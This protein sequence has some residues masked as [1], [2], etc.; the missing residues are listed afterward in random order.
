SLIVY[1]KFVGPAEPAFYD[2][3]VSGIDFAVGGIQAFSGVD[4]TNP[5]D[6]ENDANTNG[7]NHDTP[8][9]TT[10][11]NNTMLVTSHTYAS[12]R[13]WTPGT[14]GLTEAFDQ[15]SGANSAT[16][17]SISGN[18]QFD[19]TAGGTGAKR[20][21]AAGDADRG[22]THI[23]ALRPASM[24]ITIATPAG[25]LAGDVM[26]ASIGFTNPAATVPVP[27]G[28]SLLDRVDNPNGSANSL[29]VYLRVA[30]AGEPASHTWTVSGATFLVGG[31][32][33]FSGVDTVSPV[34]VKGGQ[35]TP[36]GGCGG[37]PTAHPTPD[38][39]TTVANTMLVTSH[40]FAS[41][42]TWTAPAG[43]TESFDQPNGPNNANGQSI[44]G[45]RVLQAG[46]GATGAKSATAAGNGDEGNAHIVALRPFVAVA[47]PGSFNAFET[48]TGAGAITGQV[49]TKLVATNF[50]LD[51]VAILSG[52]QLAAFNDTVQVDLVTGSTGGANC[53]GTPVAI[54]GTSQNVNLT[55]GRGA[56]GAFNAASAYPDVRVRMR[57][58]VASPTVTTCSTD[59]FTIRPVAFS[60]PASTDMTNTGSSGAPNKKAGAAFTLSVG[61]GAGYTG[62]P[63]IDSSKITAHAGAI[64]VGAL[65][66]GFG[67]AVGGT[68]SG[69]AFTYSEVG[70]FTIGINGVY[71]DAF[72]NSS[73]DRGNGDCTL[74]FSNLLVGGRYGCY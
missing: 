43:M 10:T 34:D 68:A 12:S 48:S 69:S 15:P 49:Y 57:Y 63:T 72:T 37:N 24:S 16:G 39:T 32:Q 9:V 29:A 23:V 73:T 55:S 66:G 51:V 52:A 44:S 2:W 53:P 45:H 61:G 27:A 1:R 46:I 31:I 7:T 26:I 60:A 38:V 5:I 41:S 6:V 71:D 19:P 11:V 64:Q 33:G 70:N 3:T 36:T 42:R 25:T 13:N 50:T 28:W 59:N 30:A 20:S 35:C 54:A 62:T 56:T 21:T 67:A 65:G 22:N 58:P 4:L 14:A 74:D 17:Q 47:T 40:T 8:G 18:Y